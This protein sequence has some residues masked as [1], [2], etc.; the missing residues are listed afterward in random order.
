MEKTTV[1]RKGQITIPQSLREKLG[2]KKGS[3]LSMEF[4]DGDVILSVEDKKPIE[5]MR[6]LKNEIK[7]S[8]KE[9]ESMIK[10]SKKKWSKFE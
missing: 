5:K 6:D 10:D 4:K 3:K 2:I 8:G 1:T 9:I 7:F